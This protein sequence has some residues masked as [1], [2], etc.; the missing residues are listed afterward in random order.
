MIVKPNS[1]KN[2]LVGFDAGRK[3][4]IVRVSAPADKNKAN[5][6]L[7]RFLSKNYISP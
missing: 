4:Y 1:P 3:A 2:E 5:V 7:C 6:E